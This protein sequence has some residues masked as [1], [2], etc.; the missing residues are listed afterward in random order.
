M[1]HAKLPLLQFN[2]SVS[3]S[4][5]AESPAPSTLSQNLLSIQELPP[6]YFLPELIGQQPFINR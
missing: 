3:I 1:P 5:W 6:P 2:V 4:I